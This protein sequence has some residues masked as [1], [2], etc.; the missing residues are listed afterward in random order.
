M[1]GFL[2]MGKEIWKLKLVW[3][4][5]KSRDLSSIIWREI[6]E[7]VV[8][9]KHWPWW[10]FRGCKQGQGRW[11]RCRLSSASILQTQSAEGVIDD[12]IIQLSAPLVIL[13]IL[14]GIT[15]RLDIFYHLSKII[16][17]CCMVLLSHLRRFNFNFKNLRE[18]A[19]SLHSLV[20]R[21]LSKDGPVCQKWGIE[22][23]RTEVKTLLRGTLKVK[24]WNQ[25]GPW[26]IFRKFAEKRLGHTWTCLTSKCSKGRKKRL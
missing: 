3:K 9:L 23:S 10:S 4:K 26:E 6:P 25:K 18:I 8:I 15:R 24:F 1:Q 11:Q 7:M 5:W 21:L 19:K 13:T 22:W 16:K 17:K 2:K 12:V 20:N 14:S